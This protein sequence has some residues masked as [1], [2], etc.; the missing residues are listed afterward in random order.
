VGGILDVSLVSLVSMCEH[1]GN[2]LKVLCP[3]G[4]KMVLTRCCTLATN[5]GS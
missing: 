5:E 4:K 1:G 2:G 3:P